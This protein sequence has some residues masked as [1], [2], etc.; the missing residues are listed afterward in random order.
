MVRMKPMTCAAIIL[1]AGGSSRL[2]TPKQ[3]V[4][5]KGETLIARSIHN[6]VATG[7]SPVFTVLGAN[8]EEIEAEV[9]RL[10]TISVTNEN[11]SDGMG[12]SISVGIAALLKS[13]TT[14]NAVLITLCDQPLITSQD[15]RHLIQMFQ[16]GSALIAASEYEHYSQTI[17]GVPAVFAAQLFPEL[18]K[19]QGSEGAKGIILNHES[20]T[21][22]LRI[23]AAAVDLDTTE[24]YELL[25]EIEE[26]E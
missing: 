5:Y 9:N 3:L 8:R 6:V 10:P 15:L 16:Q 25:R 19:L 17:R 14:V 1:G 7:C 12:S 22:F 4:C 23:P 11:W 2:G 13:D 24:D 26:S 20:E 21:R 18:R